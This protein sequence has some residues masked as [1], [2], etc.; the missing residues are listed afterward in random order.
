MTAPTLALLS[1]ATFFLVALLLGVWKYRQM[2]A[3]PD[4]LAHPYV[5]IAHRASLLYSFAAAMLAYFAEVSQ[6][7][8]GLEL[9]A[10]SLLVGYFALAII[11]YIGHGYRRDTDNQVRDINT[12]GKVFLWSLVVAEIGGFLIIFYGLVTALL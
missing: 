6:L 7:A 12:A 8:N 1:A 3:S 11:G 4:G 9:F 2:V 10:I 5:D